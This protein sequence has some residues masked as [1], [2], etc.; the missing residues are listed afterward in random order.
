MK[1]IGR[2]SLANNMSDHPYESNPDYSANINF[3]HFSKDKKLVVAY[4]EAPKGWF[5]WEYDG[6]YEIDYI[7][8]G[9]IELVSEDKTIIVKKGDCFLTED[10]EKI[11][12]KIK[13]FTKA[14]I[15]VYPANEIIMRDIKKLISGRKNCSPNRNHHREC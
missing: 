6:F 1:L 2:D 12:F 10:G 3:F 7:I 14:L 4:W 13:K 11:K 8:E 5:I 9:E 15:L